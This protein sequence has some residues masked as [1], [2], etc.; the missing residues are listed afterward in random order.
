MLALIIATFL[1]GTDAG[2]SAPTPVDE[3][4]VGADVS[5]ATLA[6]PTGC[7]R[8]LWD[9]GSSSAFQLGLNGLTGIEKPM[10]HCM[11]GVGK[12]SF[13]MPGVGKRPLSLQGENMHTPIKI[14]PALRNTR[15]PN[16]MSHATLL[17]MDWHMPL[18]CLTPKGGRMDIH[19]TGNLF[20]INLPEPS[21]DQAW[22][23]FAEDAPTILHCRMGHRSK[24]LI[25]EQ[26]SSGDLKGCPRSINLAE[27]RRKPRSEIPEVCA[28]CQFAKAHKQPKP[29]TH[30]P[31][32]PHTKDPMP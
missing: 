11:N 10:G 28:E 16:V 9:S 4:R 26:I 23:L 3:I 29:A 1:P 8:Y 25:I 2:K 15:H 18:H 19:R 13:R 27:E 30:S 12:G 32:K 20:H 24:R 14:C 21:R 22:A 7:T 6:C 5:E 31:A 17:D